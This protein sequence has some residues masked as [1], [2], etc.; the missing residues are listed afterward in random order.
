MHENQKNICED[1]RNALGEY[2]IDSKVLEIGSL[3]VNG[4]IKYLFNNCEYVGVDVVK[5]DN[6]D[7]VSIAHELDFESDFDVVFSC[8]SIEHDMHIEKTIDK[9]MDL[10]K[11][12][13]LIFVTTA[14]M[15]EHGTKRSS[16][17]DSGTS[18]LNNEWAD[19][20]KMYNM[21]SFKSLFNI[22]EF[23]SCAFS[24]RGLDLVFWGIKE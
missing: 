10:C 4:N 16:P 5:G 20:F 12:G 3:D 11:A 14:M 18:S 21:E 17:N 8:N 19:Y 2:F 13:G 15:G 24:Q 6:V 22:D 23:S 9:M 1:L 7:I